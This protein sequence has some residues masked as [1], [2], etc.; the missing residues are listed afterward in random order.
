[1]PRR[2]RRRRRRRLHRGLGHG[3]AGSGRRC[4]AAAT[5]ASRC[6]CIHRAAGCAQLPARRGRHDAAAHHRRAALRPAG[7]LARDG[8]ERA[9]GGGARARKHAARLRAGRLHRHGQPDARDERHAGHARDPRDGLW[10][11]HRRHHRRSARQPG[12]RGVRG[13]WPR[14]VHRQDDGRHAAHRGASPTAR[15]LGRAQARCALLAEHDLG[16][17]LTRC[18][19][20]R[21]PAADRGAAHERDPRDQQPHWHQPARQPPQ[22]ARQPALEP[23]Q[24]QPS[25]PQA[26][27]DRKCDARVPRQPRVSL[28]RRD[29][30]RA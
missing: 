8:V 4:A 18:H 27:S 6:A 3:F 24:P 20:P 5:P 19:L 9:R 30:E 23:S 15:R 2:W 16:R 21:R 14:H 12:S 25:S 17:T 11:V 26:L 10:R 28:I 13:G 1:M 22:P 29:D 7:H